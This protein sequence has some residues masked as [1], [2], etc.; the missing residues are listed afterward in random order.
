MSYSARVQA[1][2]SYEVGTCGRVFGRL[3]GRLLRCMLGRVLV[4]FDTV[5]GRVWVALE[6][7]RSVS[8]TVSGSW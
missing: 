4:A 1:R 5:F 8:T 6:V 7:L 3:L 2:A